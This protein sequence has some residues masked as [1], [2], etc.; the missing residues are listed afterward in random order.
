MDVLGM[1]F[2]GYGPGSNLCSEMMEKTCVLQCVAAGHKLVH[3]DK[4]SKNKFGGAAT[5]PPAS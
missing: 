5:C 3:K 4:F 2:H 1:W